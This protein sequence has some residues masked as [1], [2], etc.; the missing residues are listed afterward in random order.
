LPEWSVIESLRKIGLNND[1]II[2]KVVNLVNKQTQ[3]HTHPHPLT[4]IINI[5]INTHIQ[6]TFF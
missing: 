3:I 6:F 2:S 4:N 5:I 1:V